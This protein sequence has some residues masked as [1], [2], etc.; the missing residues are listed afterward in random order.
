MPSDQEGRQDR[1]RTRTAGG[2]KW[3]P[4]SLKAITSPLRSF[5]NSPIRARR[6]KPTRRRGSTCGG[7]SMAKPTNI[8]TTEQSTPPAQVVAA[9]QAVLPEEQVLLLPANANGSSG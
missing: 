1:F 9:L 3:C 2:R 5:A 6:E 4:S 8:G 7:L